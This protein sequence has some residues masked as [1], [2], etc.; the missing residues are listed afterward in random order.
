MLFSFISEIMTIQA[1]QNF[2]MSSFIFFFSDTFIL[3]TQNKVQEQRIWYKMFMF[4][5]ACSSGCCTV[6][7]ANSLLKKL[8]KENKSDIRKTNIKTT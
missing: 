2:L 7:F 6:V 8:K 1:L 3:F 5:G 4:W